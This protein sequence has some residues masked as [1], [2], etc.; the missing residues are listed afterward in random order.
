MPQEL[1]DAGQ[2]RARRRPYIPVSAY[3]IPLRL[4]DF[5]VPGIIQLDLEDSIVAASVAPPSVDQRRHCAYNFGV[6]SN[7][8]VRMMPL[9]SELASR[10]CDLASTC[11]HVHSAC[12]CLTMPSSAAVLPQDSLPQTESGKE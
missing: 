8:L 5:V 6:L 4:P 3:A 7:I 11:V 10:G 2:D 12:S 1:K 9:L